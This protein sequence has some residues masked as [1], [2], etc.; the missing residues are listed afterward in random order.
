MVAILSEEEVAA[1]EM[2]SLCREFND[3]IPLPELRNLMLQEHR[4]AGPCAKKIA[5]C[6]HEMIADRSH[7]AAETSPWFLA[8]RKGHE[9]IPVAPNAA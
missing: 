5:G 7:T 8:S 3:N 1:K 9:G 2:A 4:P 6:C